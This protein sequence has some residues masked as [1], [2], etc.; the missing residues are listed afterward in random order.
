MAKI[1]DML[2]DC[3]VVRRWRRCGTSTRPSHGRGQ[4]AEGPDKPEM[5]MHGEHERA[6]RISRSSSSPPPGS[7]RRRWD[8]RGR[9]RSLRRK[10]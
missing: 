5:I 6:G 1:R 7:S 8:K 3:W 4:A 9:R 2:G 10:A